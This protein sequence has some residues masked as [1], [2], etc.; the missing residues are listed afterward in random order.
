MS[1]WVLSTLVLFADSA[2]FLSIWIM[3][4]ICYPLG[5]PEAPLNVTKKIVTVQTA[6]KHLQYRNFSAVS[7]IITFPDATI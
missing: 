1:T 3:P 7:L 5:I 2:N 6:K 4:T